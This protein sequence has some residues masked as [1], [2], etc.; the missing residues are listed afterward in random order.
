MVRHLLFLSL[1][2]C[3]QI[4]PAAAQTVELGSRLFWLG[5]RPRTMDESSPFFG[6]RDI[7]WIEEVVGTEPVF[8]GTVLQLQQFGQ[9]ADQ[10]VSRSLEKRNTHEVVIEDDLVPPRFR[11]AGY[12]VY[13]DERSTKPNPIYVPVDPASGYVVRCGWVVGEERFSVC[14]VFAT[15]PPDDNIWL[16]AR[17]YFPPDP[18]EQPTRFRD[19]V[20]RLREV[21]ECLDVTDKLVDVPKVYPDLKGCKPEET[22]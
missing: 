9:F 8:D 11:L 21:A 6:L 1:C 14:S 2:L 22:S 18:I 12:R 16:T 5:E 3:L 17:L 20:E 15:Y 19:V 7:E 4:K 13:G 10:S